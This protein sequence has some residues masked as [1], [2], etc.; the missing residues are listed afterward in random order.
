MP[1]VKSKRFPAVYINELQS[2]IPNSKQRDKSYYV[3]VQADSGWKKIKIGKHSHGIT[4]T[5]ANNKRIE[6][7]NLLNN[8]VDP[9]AEKKK[10]QALLFDS[11]AKLYFKKLQDL[12]RK[13]LYNPTNRYK[14]HIKQELGNKNILHIT[15]QDILR[16]KDK[17]LKTHSIASTRHIISLISSMY[18]NAIEDDSVSFKGPN[19]AA[20]IL[21]SRDLKKTVSRLNY[22]SVEDVQKL[23]KAV[24]DDKEVNMFSR[25]A[26]STGGRLQSIMNL[27]KKDLNDRN[28]SLQNFK[29]GGQT[30]Q[31]FLSQQLFENITIFD[32]LN[33]NDYLVGGSKEIYSDRKIQRRLKKVLDELFNAHLDVKDTENRIVVHS[34]RH[35]FASLLVAGGTDLYKVMKLMSHS[36]LAMT[37]KYS[38][39]APDSGKENVHNLLS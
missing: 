14:K 21:Q 28:V 22:L 23:L 35:T 20:G 18:K 29:T 19:V 11:I 5:Y 10:K 31:G 32:E 26:L 13:D 6:F 15:K 33:P 24:A 7:L 16:I 38:H 2:F 25:L 4:E 12:E 1:M 34:L 3:G 17:M 9:R 27:Q 36:D 8:G 39:L 30:Y 37:M